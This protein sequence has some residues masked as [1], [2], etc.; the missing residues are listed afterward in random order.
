MEEEQQQQQQQQQ[1][2][3]QGSRRRLMAMSTIRP[4]V[5]PDCD[6]GPY[7]NFVGSFSGSKVGGLA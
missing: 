7:L 2:H 1:Q 4:L 5:L 3:H 6:F